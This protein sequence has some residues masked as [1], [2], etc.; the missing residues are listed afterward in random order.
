[1][2]LS[3]YSLDQIK[4][5]HNGS[6]ATARAEAEKARAYRNEIEARE[7]RFCGRSRGRLTEAVTALFVARTFA[8]TPHDLAADQNPYRTT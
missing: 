3:T 7:P 1:M 5:L 2:D 6:L 4:T 8:N